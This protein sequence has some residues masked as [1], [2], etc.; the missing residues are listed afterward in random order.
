MYDSL[1]L[2]KAVLSVE[3]VGLTPCVGWRTAH[4]ET[5]EQTLPRTAR[6]ARTSTRNCPANAVL[7]NMMNRSMKF[8]MKVPLRLTHITAHPFQKLYEWL[9]NKYQCEFTAKIF[10]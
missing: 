10:T 7:I 4:T 5:S 3:K 9:A 6:S 1:T 2:S 8:Q